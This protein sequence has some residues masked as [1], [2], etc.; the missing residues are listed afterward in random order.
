MKINTYKNMTSLVA[1]DNLWLT[2]KEDTDL[3]NRIFSKEIY[4]AVTDSV[5]NYTEVDQTKY[6]EY[7]LEIKKNNENK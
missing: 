2:N 6:D 7:Q 1:E 5:D 4:L 3:T